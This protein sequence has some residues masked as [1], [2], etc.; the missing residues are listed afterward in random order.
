MKSEQ[1]EPQAAQEQLNQAID[2]EARSTG[3]SGAVS[4]TRKEQALTAR[5]YGYANL[6]EERL[7]QFNTRFGIASGCKLFTAVAVCQLV[8]QGK[9][10]FDSKVL[11]VLQDYEFPRF[12]PEITVHQLLTHSS[13]IPDYFDEEVMDDFAA[14]WKETPMYTL[15]RPA[16]FLPL[17]AAL[18]M[19]FT[20]GERFHYNNAGYIMLG[21]LVEA[22]SGMKFTD[23]VE[24]Q[25]FRPCGMTDSG[26]FAQDALPANTA[27]GYTE[28]EH[29]E[30]INNVYSLPVVGGPD[31][32]AFVTAADMQRLWIGLFWHTLLLP[33]TTELL[34]T[35][36][37]REDEDSYYGYGV[38]IQVRNG[39]VIKYHVMGSDPGVSFRSAVYPASG[40]TFTALCNR[41]RGAYRMMQVLEANLPL[42]QEDDHP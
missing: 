30:T 17:F 4:V 18:P 34:L 24:Q 22:V 5:A 14:L 31:G 19:K 40:V 6:A 2:N 38:W 7:N 23:Y 36:H 11:T 35:P 29:G 33:A 42:Q 41:S 10:S 37:I 20:P 12:S 3:F 21:L 32:G 39:K 9:L 26:Y 16:D 1:R 15:R 13:G 27:L 25:I 28:N 8:E